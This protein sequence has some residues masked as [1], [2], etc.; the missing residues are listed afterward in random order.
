MKNMIKIDT[1]EYDDYSGMCKNSYKAVINLKRI[2]SITEYMYKEYKILQIGMVN[3]VISEND[4]EMI[5]DII[6]EIN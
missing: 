5:W 4:A 2:V 6:N 3:I 1:Y